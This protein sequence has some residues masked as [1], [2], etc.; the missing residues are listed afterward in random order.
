MNVI[1]FTYL[2]ICLHQPPHA[3]VQ[4]HSDAGG[5]VVGGDVRDAL[6]GGTYESK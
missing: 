6:P 4:G 2:F 3:A 5:D 1:F